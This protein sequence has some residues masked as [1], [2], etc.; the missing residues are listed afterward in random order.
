MTGCIVETGIEAHE[1]EGR[2][3]SRD[4]CPNLI[5]KSQ[6]DGEKWQESKELE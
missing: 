1:K 4:C 2:N 3:F 6:D 5:E